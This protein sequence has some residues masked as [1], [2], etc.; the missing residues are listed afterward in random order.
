M[1][2]TVQTVLDRLTRS[3]GRLEPTVDT[4]KSGRG[5]A[6]VRKVAVVFMATYAAIKQAVESGADLIVTHE[7]TYYNHMDESEWLSGNLVYK[8]KLALIEESGVSIFRLHDYVHSYKPDGILIGMLKK[9]DWETYADPEEMNLLTVPPGKQHTVRT[10]VSHLKSKLGIE[11]MLVGGDLD[12]QVRR[13]GLIP[14]ASGGRS[15]IEYLGNRDIDLLI[16]GETN[17]WETN[18]Y[19]RDA[20]DMG[21]AKALI[22]TGHQKSEEVGMLTVVEMLCEAFPELQVTFIAIPLAVQRI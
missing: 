13:F 9:L 8:R 5:D 10:I 4:L 19:V 20:S 22:I 3:V 18:E 12:L 14:G 7:P 11:S 21:L 17:E 15:H 6:E 2:I 16:V 1:A